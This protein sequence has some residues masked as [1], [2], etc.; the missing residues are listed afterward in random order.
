MR[1]VILIGVL[2]AVTAGVL[3][4]PGLLGGG[5]SPSGEGGDRPPSG[6]GPTLTRPEDETLQGTPPPVEQPEPQR[7]RLAGPMR[8]LLLADRPGSWNV[9]HAAALRTEPMIEVVAW[10]SDPRGGAQLGSAPPL[11][12]TPT[13]AWFEQQDFQLLV[14]AQLDPRALEPAF[15]E[16][17][18]GRVRAGSLGLWVQPGLPLPMPGSSEQPVMHPLL[19]QPA[20]ATVLPVASAKPIQGSPLPGVFAKNAPFAVTSTG[21]KHLASRMVYWPEWSR[22]IWQLGVS[23]AEPWGSMF[24][25]PVETLK[26]GSVVLVEAR[27]PTGSPIPVYV[28]GPPSLGRVLWFGAQDFG[29]RTYYDPKAGTQW[30]ALLRNAAIWLAGRAPPEEVLR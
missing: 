18:A 1:I 3:L 8:V 15:W 19:E 30:Q 24:C 28:I 16:A 29:H 9:F 14:V 27:P 5:E 2:L 17:V 20:L 11:G 12:S 23:G 4:L 21:E 10:V 7:L 26:E 22:R 25:Y 6:D 13:A